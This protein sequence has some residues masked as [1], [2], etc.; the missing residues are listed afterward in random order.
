MKNNYQSLNQYPF[1]KAQFTPYPSHDPITFLITQNGAE[2]YQN[3]ET[4]DNFREKTDFEMV[5]SWLIDWVHSKC[6][7]TDKLI[8]WLNDLESSVRLI[9]WLVDWMTWDL[10]FDWLIDWC[11]HWRPVVTRASHLFN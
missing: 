3:L 1:P 8:D 10:L 9:D 2:N 11:M 4:L 6:Q 5:A 7:G